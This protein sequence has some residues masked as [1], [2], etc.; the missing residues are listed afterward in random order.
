MEYLAIGSK[1]TL[2]KL[3]EEGL[4]VHDLGGMHRFDREEVDAWLRS[5]CSDLTPDGDAS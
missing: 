3:R 2:R 5:R 4:P 1:T